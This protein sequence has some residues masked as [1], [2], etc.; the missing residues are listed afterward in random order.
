MLLPLADFFLFGIPADLAFEA[1]SFS[2]NMFPR[3]VPAQGAVP[4]SSASGARMA[5]AQI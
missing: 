2:E 1:V 3:F 4:L 5:S